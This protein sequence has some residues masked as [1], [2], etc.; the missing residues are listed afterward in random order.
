M[1]ALI[2]Q[3]QRLTIKRPIEKPICAQPADAHGGEKK[4]EERVDCMQS[5][6]ENNVARLREY[7][8]RSKV[9][10]EDE[11]LQRKTLKD[12]HIYC[13]LHGISAQQY[14]PLLEKYIISKFGYTKN[15]ASQCTGDCSK[16]GQNMEV[17]TSLG[18]AQNNKFNYVQLRMSQNIQ[19]YFFTAYHLFEENVEREGELYIFRIPKE[20]MKQL[21]LH[22]GGYAHGTVK[23]LGEITVESMKDD[24][25]QREYALRP[26][27]QDKCWKD[28]LPFRI[29]E[30]DI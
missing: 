13:I 24:S 26:R 20:N 9:K 23:E 15:T 17:K 30:K 29:D 22:H 19:T 10:H 2:H 7:M 18:G 27:F 14:G 28:L 5:E 4:E 16:Q 8:S 21:I 6:R 11:I 12:A 3:I 1:N 25:H